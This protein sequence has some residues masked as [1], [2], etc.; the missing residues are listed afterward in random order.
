MKKK[1]IKLAKRDTV[2]FR[3]CKPH[4]VAHTLTY[5]SISLDLKLFDEKKTW[6]YVEYFI[7]H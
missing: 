1:R 5:I 4:H 3:I 7:F 6:L 2:P